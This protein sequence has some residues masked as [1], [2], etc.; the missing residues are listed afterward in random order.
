MAY[1]KK[2]IK[3]YFDK[4]FENQEYSEHEDGEE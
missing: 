2:T 4:E 1:E 3:D